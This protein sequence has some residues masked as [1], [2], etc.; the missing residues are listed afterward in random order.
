EIMVLRDVA[1]AELTGGRLHLAHVSTAGSVRALREAKRRGLRVT[2]EVSPHHLTLTDDAVASS[3]YDTDFKMSPPLRSR[4]DVRACQEAL[5]DGTIDCIATDHAPH[6]DVEKKLEFDAA[7]NGVVGLETAFPVCLE[8]VKSGALSEKR[9]IEAFTSAPA[10]AFKL[11]GGS[12]ARGAP[13]D[14]AILD[15]AE[16]WTADPAAFLSRGKNSPWK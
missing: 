1:L 6:S 15:P 16:R 14:I 11:P 2:A 7:A 9:L 8:L 4:E 5:A 10:R 3:G 12:L 13:A